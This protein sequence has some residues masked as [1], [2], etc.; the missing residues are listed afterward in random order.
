MNR[1]WQ[2]FADEMEIKSSLVF[3]TVES[4]IKNVLG[5]IS[6]VK[7]EIEKQ[8]LP[9][10]GRTF[11]DKLAS[12]IRKSAER[13]LRLQTYP[14]SGNLEMDMGIPPEEEERLGPA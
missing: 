9:E 8:S 12:H 3:R 2:R 11:L 4:V 7:E 10:S 1:H 13:A 14:E 6:S 5:E